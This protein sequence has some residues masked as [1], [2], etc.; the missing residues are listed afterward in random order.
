[1]QEQDNLKSKSIKGIWGS[2]IER[3]SIQGITFILNIVIAR[4]VSP[5]EYGLIAM[6][7]IFIAV[8]QMFIDSG[9][10]NA[11]IQKKSRSQVDFSTAFYFNIVVGL[12]VYALLWMSAPYI[13]DFYN[14]PLLKSIMR[15][16]GINIILSSFSI[17]QRAKL[18]I[19][20]DFT[21]QAKA[22]L[23]GVV[24]SGIIGITMAYYGYGVWAL[25]TQAVLNTLLYTIMMWVLAHWRPTLEYSWQSFRTLF[26]F[27]SRY[28]GTGLI[29]VIYVNMY[30]LVIGKK[31]SAQQVG[32]Y[33]RASTIGQFPSMN[34]SYIITRAMFPAM[35][36][37]QDDTQRLTN[38]FNQT[39]R[40][41]CYIIFPMSIGLAVVAEPLIDVVLTE[42]WANAASLLQIL[43]VAY[44]WYPIMSI[45]HTILTVKG[46]TDYFLRAEIIKKSLGVI[47]MLVTM[48]MGVKALCWGLLAYSFG[49]M[50]VTIF[51][52]KKVVLTGYIAQIK[53]IAPLVLLTAAMGAIAYSSMLITDNQMLKIVIGVISGCL[54]YLGISLLFRFGEMQTALDIL[55]KK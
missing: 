39:L 37:I 33:N 16:I 43:C 30:T 1:M 5:E 10:S 48:P 40:M 34:I 8:S 19:K 53:A 2:A 41:A 29:N 54:S 12:V 47:I 18:T 35:C 26:A 13:A 14:Q 15:W 38:Y 6:L 55:K 4:M 25:V 3:F 50:A 32:F 49:D 36:N 46:R 22:S 11:L 45:N 20:L 31:F 9:F 7:G 28:L 23:I 27:G 42:K 24:I 44:M 17:V 51:F 21:T 52:A